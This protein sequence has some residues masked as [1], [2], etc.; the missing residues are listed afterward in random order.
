[1]LIML[2]HT[3]S[4]GFFYREEQRETGDSNS[5]IETGELQPFPVT[6]DGV[7]IYESPERIISL[8]PAFTEILFEFGYGDRLI[9]RSPHCN[10]PTGVSSIE[11]FE[12]G[13]GFDVDE[14]LSAAPDLLLLSSPIAEISR[15]AILREGIAILV[16]PPPQSVEDFREM[17]RLL[18][19][20]LYGGF[21]GEE[22]GDLA[23]LPLTQVLNNSEAVNIG[24]FVYVT[25]N[26]AFATGDTFESSVLSRFGDNLAKE[27]VGYQFNREQLL[28]EQPDVILL[29]DVF[30]ITDLQTD[31]L[32]A[33]LEAV[34]IG[35]VI[36]LNN[37]YFERP[38]GRIVE[39]ISSIISQYG[40]FR[41]DPQ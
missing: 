16:L 36:V 30:T 37:S 9:G 5:G 19:V 2:V 21:I 17:Y 13:S 3:T 11:A 35:R 33:Q 25:E 24:S 41:T 34:T 31:D 27:G 26:M 23:F 7:A 12:V 8:S 40:E 28:E 10:Y 18:G 4:C 15:V 29:S 14:I 32:F 6:I 38:S 22:M 20:I 1:M 39:L